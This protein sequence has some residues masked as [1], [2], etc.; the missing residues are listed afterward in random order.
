MREVVRGRGQWREGGGVG[1]KCGGE[2][3]RLWKRWDGELVGGE[4]WGR[5]GRG[6][7]GGGGGGGWG[8]GSGAEGGGGGGE[9]VRGDGEGGI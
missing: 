4:G 9:E 7:G 5:R 1:E 6:V 8:G 3:A 2:G